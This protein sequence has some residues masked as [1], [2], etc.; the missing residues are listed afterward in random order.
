MRLDAWRARSHERRGGTTGERRRGN[1]ARAVRVLRDTR[2][3]R[4]RSGVGRRGGALLLRRR[5]VA[6]LGLRLLLIALLRLLRI[7]LLLLRVAA[8]LWIA[9]LLRIL[10]R[11]RI[12]GAGGKRNTQEET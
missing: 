2:N 5:R 3:G 9:S 8:L 6:L 1:R 12:L 7:A 11:R 4:R 10:R